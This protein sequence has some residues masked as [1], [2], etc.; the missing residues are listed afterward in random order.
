MADVSTE[1]MLGVDLILV[2]LIILVFLGVLAWRQ[3]GGHNLT[4]LDPAHRVQVISYRRGSYLVTTADGK[5]HTFGERNLRLM[6][7]S[8]ESGPPRGAPALINVGILE[9]RADI[10]FAAFEEISS[11]VKQD[12]DGSA[13]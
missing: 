12:A 1:M 2:L 8:S 3:S 13:C 6:I 7:D 4:A 10:I 9:D 5:T 11:F